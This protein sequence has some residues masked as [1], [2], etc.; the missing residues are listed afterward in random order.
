MENNLKSVSILLIVGILSPINAKFLL[1]KLKGILQND[2]LNN[3][4]SNV[5]DA[6]IGQNESTEKID[7]RDV[8]EDDP[9]GKWLDNIKCQ[10]GHFNPRKVAFQGPLDPNPFPLT[11]LGNSRWKCSRACLKEKECMYAELL[12]FPDQETCYLKKGCGG[13]NHVQPLPDPNFQVWFRGYKQSEFC[14]QTHQCP[15]DKPRCY[16]LCIPICGA[17]GGGICIY[18]GC[19]VNDGGYRCKSEFEYKGKRYFECTKAGGYDTP[20]CYDVSGSWDWCSKCS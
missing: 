5:N 4:L 10:Y 19:L 13:S 16:D 18:D 15:N 17:G 2:Q 12:W 6:S 1:I 8:N 9:A 3:S 7:S 20:W 14:T 11:P